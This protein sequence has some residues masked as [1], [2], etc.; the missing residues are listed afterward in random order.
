MPERVK[1]GAPA[2]APAGPGEGAFF[3]DALGLPLDEFL[4]NIWGQRAYGPHACAP[5][6]Q[7][8]GV[9]VMADIDYLLSQARFQ[10]VHAQPIRNGAALPD[11]R[12]TDAGA[13]ADAAYVYGQFAKG[14]SFRFI[15][16]QR[17][18]P[19]VA[20]FV[21]EF[22]AALAERVNANIYL[23]PANS[24]GLDV[25]YDSHDV[26]VLQCVGSKRWRLY[27][28]DYADARERPTGPAF[29]F[30]PAHHSPGRV[31]RDVELTPGDILYLPRGILHEVAP[32]S[33][34]SLHVTFGVHLLTVADLAHRALR[35]AVEEVEGLRRTV[36]HASRMDEQLAT[37]LAAALTSHRLAKVLEA[38]RRECRQRPRAPAEHYFAAH[39]SPVDGVARLGAAIAERVRNGE[40][41]SVPIE[42][43]RKA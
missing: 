13:S 19:R 43:K 26:F 22:A 5:G 31:D 15:D 24:E 3:R 9:A 23:S 36:A 29:R 4:S 34:D 10:G 40:L 6:L 41:S 39:R 11:R 42:P 1:D 12:T 18:L 27:V 28:D 7:A 35:L 32:P 8:A 16:A 2:A 14:V 37:D 33:G 21:A 20:D 38:Y 30:D 17:Y 25:H